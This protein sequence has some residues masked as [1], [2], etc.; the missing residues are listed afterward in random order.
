MLLPPHVEERRLDICAVFHG[1]DRG[2]RLATCLTR[3]GRRKS[4][5]VLLGKHLEKYD[6]K[7]G[8]LRLRGRRIVLDSLLNHGDVFLCP[9]INILPVSRI[10]MYPGLGHAVS[11]SAQLRN[12][13]RL[14]YV[15]VS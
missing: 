6:C 8:R 7:I 1:L 14:T 13:M 3:Y 5:R 15:L 12:Y 2:D 10:R 11:A 4:P 9:I